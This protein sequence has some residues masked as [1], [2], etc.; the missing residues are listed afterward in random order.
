MRSDFLYRTNL[1]YEVKSLRKQVADFESGEKYGNMQKEY[2]KTL[3][4]MER[5]IRQLKKEL[6][7]SHAETIGVRNKWFQTC[8]DILKEKEQ[9]L[10]RKDR[11]L[12]KMA[13][14]V[15]EAQRQRDEALDKLRDKNLKL[16]E[17]ETRLEESQG[18]LL[19]LTARV[20]RDHTNSSIS[21]SLKPN[22]KKIQN[23]REKTGRKPGGQP[24]HV[25]N[26]RKRQDPTQTVEIPAPDEYANGDNYKPTGKLIRKQRIILRVTTEVIEYVTPEFRNQTTGQRVHAAFPE[27]LRDEV[28][29]DGSVKAAAYLLNNDCYVS[30]DKT[31]T[32]LKEISD[33]KIDLSNGMIS[34]LARQFSEKT[35]EERDQIFLELLTSPSMHA[36]FTFG[37]M[38]GK[39]ASVI[40]CATPGLVLYQGREKKG[41]EGVKGSPV[42]LYQGTIIA[43]HEATF[44]NYGTRHQECMIHVERYVRSSIENEPALEWNRQMLKWIQSA[45]H[46]FNERKEG[47]GDDVVVVDEE[48]VAQFVARYDEI[49][50]KAREEYEYEPPSDYFRD[51][52]NLYKRMSDDKEDY[53]LFLHDPSV[54][55]SN[56]LAERCGRKFK[57]KVAQVMGFR[58]MDGVRYFCD[59][60][61]VI[62]TVKSNGENLYDAVISRFNKRGEAG[63]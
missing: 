18:K 43:D 13:E 26:S 7:C 52:Y 37:R 4:G 3:A 53:R 48:Q 47:A 14:G 8:E 50:E 29:Y 46:Y 16:Y 57:R 32:F 60:L 31:R 12:Y 51:G 20:N 22:H 19:E 30:I 21:S 61:S 38:N 54:E 28:N 36:D 10:A 62:Q 55:P 45:L 11:E 39:Q 23:G 6:A 58:S 35:Q 1:Q 56:N 9:D 15:L 59:G 25:H 63:C 5:Q 41:H 40:L 2:R 24:G 33:G 27:G 17:A 49:I 42:E 34:N 44:Q